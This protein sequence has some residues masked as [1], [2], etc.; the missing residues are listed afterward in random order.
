MPAS[1]H[2]VHS[3]WLINNFANFS[4]YFLFVMKMTK[5]L[6]I[7]LSHR[8]MFPRFQMFGIVV[9]NYIF[10][11]FFN[12]YKNIWKLL[13]SINYYQ[14]FIIHHFKIFCNNR[15]NSLTL[16]QKDWNLFNFK[17]LFFLQLKA[18]INIIFL[19][20]IY[21]VY[22]LFNLAYHLIN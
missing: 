20:L 18:Y 1:M 13:F 19:S 3:I 11:F 8:S 9:G 5:V 12:N 17:L 15:N 4:I 7:L 2:K 16:N 10:F 6:F 22:Y 14:Q 21:H